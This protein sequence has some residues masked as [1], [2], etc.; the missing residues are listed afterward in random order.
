MTREAAR[1]F[2]ERMRTDEDF[3]EKVPAVEGT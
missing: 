1:A 2:V 3:R